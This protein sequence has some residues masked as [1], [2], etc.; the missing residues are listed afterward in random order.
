MRASS[1]LV[2]FFTCLT[3]QITSQ[4][5]VPEESW[6]WTFVVFISLTALAFVSPE[7]DILL[8]VKQISYGEIVSGLILSA[9]A[10]L[11]TAPIVG[12]LIHWISAFIFY[13]SALRVLKH[14][15]LYLHKGVKKDSQ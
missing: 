8:A 13:I 3:V 2:I 5:I 7:R 6:F 10:L 14:M 11:P 12:R 15:F 4:R 1:I 9:F